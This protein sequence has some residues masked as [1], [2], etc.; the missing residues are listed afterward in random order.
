VVRDCI[1]VNLSRMNILVHLLLL[2]LFLFLL[3]LL[4]LPSLCT[5]LFVGLCRPVDR[6]LRLVLVRHDPALGFCCC[7]QEL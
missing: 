2:Y 7:F 3:L 6:L 5:S 1:K 4:L